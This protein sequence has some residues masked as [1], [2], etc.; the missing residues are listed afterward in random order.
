MVRRCETCGAAVPAGK[1]SCSVCGTAIKEATQKVE[2]VESA[3]P[4]ATENRN[5]IRIAVVSLLVLLVWGLYSQVSSCVSYSNSLQDWPTSGFAQMVPVA[6]TKCESVSELSDSLH[7][8]SEKGKVDER[9]FDAYV[10]G[11]KAAGYV[12]D[13]EVYAKVYV[14]YNDEGYKVRVSWSDSDGQMNVD[15]DA[16]LIEGGFSWPT[17]GLA[18]MLPSLEKTKGK[19]IYD[20][21]SDFR[22]YVGDVSPEEFSDYANWC[23]DSGYNID[24]SRGE[25]LFKADNSDG[26]HISLQYEG[27]NTMSLSLSQ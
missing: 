3:A 11:C 23:F 8:R 14:A 25:D 1:S 18:T 12:I 17:S 6:K 13:P 27:F 15:L 21:S 7:I 10:E 2:R 24:F 26:W 20:S 19:I 22:A 16:P 4:Q 9:A 5:R